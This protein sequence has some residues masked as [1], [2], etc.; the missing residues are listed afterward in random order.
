MQLK[1]VLK[2]VDFIPLV[3]SPKFWI[4]PDVLGFGSVLEVQEHIG[5]Q[6]L[7]AYPGSFEVLGYGSAKEEKKKRT[8]KVDESDLSH[9]ESESFTV[10]E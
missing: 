10:G 9:G 2:K 4:S 3:K 6:L 8:K 5:H 1:C 7:A